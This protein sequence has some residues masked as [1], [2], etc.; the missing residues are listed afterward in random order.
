[1]N[2]D[3]K[4]TLLCEYCNRTAPDV[5]NRTKN[6]YRKYKGKY[7]CKK[8][9]GKRIERS[10]IM[11][12]DWKKTLHCDLDD[13]QEL[14]THNEAY[15]TFIIEHGLENDLGWAIFEPAE[16]SCLLN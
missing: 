1:M 4:K 9:Q 12:I 13:I 3:W 16:N 10:Y 15:M 7:E 8:C 2:I 5:I 14:L 6:I 11:N